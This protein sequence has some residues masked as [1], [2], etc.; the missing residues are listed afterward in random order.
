MYRLSF[1]SSGSGNLTETI[2]Q[3]IENGVLT[4]V[5][6]VSIISDRK[7]QSLEL[8]KRFNLNEHIIEFKNANSRE[9][10]S[11]KILKIFQEEKI[12]FSFSTFDRILS[13]KILREYKNKLINM[14]P[15]LLPAFPGY[16]TIEKA[17][18]YGTKFIGA[19]CHFI[20]EGIDTGPI[21]N[22]GILP[23]NVEED[24]K[25]TQ[26]KLYYLRK[27]LALEAIYAYA[28]K[29]ITVKDRN[30]L[31]KNANYNSFEVNPSID[32]SSSKKI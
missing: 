10:A 22:Q 1:L 12:D 15:S 28:N 5:L 26:E 14:H 30:V 25:T 8:A 9:E 19:T 18:E 31:I 27:R 17:R 20:D 32:I 13:G 11:D 7:S 29:Y 23:Y 6:P 24:L 3:A 21:I 4:N 16:N 2:L